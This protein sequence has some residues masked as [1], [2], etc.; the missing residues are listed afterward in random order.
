M[1][2]PDPR[3]ACLDD[4]LSVHG[5]RRMARSRPQWADLVVAT[6][7]RSFSLTPETTIELAFRSGAF[8]R[9]YPRGPHDL[10]RTY[11]DRGSTKR[12]A[13]VFVG[14]PIGSFTDADLR[15]YADGG[16]GG[17]PAS[18]NTRERDAALLRAALHRFAEVC[19]VPSSL[20]ARARPRPGRRNRPPRAP[21]A[22]VILFVLAA[23]LRPLRRAMALALGAGAT[24]AELARV[25]VS[26]VV[27]LRDGQVFVLLGTGQQR[28]AV[29]LPPW[30]TQILVDGTTAEWW[31]RPQRPLIGL[32]PEALQR[33]LRTAAQKAN[34]EA[35]SVTLTRLR[36]AWQAILGSR[37]APRAVLRGRWGLPPRAERRGPRHWSE[38]ARSLYAPS[39]ALATRWKVLSEPPGGWPEHALKRPSGRTRPWEREVKAPRLPPLPPSVR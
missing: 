23:A 20:D 19:G 36:A 34:I 28:R 1:R 6:R 13:G 14:R 32:S 21:Q 25:V 8:G 30:C 10:D 7:P 29:A 2:S 9:L 11:A 3:P 24:P 15:A 18:A 31:R 27:Q 17:T 37:G 38:R 22:E 35:G 26:D 5:L 39:L 4:P 12:L 16:L 33:A